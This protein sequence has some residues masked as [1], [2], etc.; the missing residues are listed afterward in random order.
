MSEHECKFI[1][2]QCICGAMLMKRKILTKQEVNDLV[3][4]DKDTSN[5]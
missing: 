2:G 4:T 5:D 1:L 3:A